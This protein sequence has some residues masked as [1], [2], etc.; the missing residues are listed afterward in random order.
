MEDRDQSAAP[1]AAIRPSPGPGSSRFLDE[2]LGRFARDFK[3][4]RAA[5]MLYDPVSG[6]LSMRAARGFPAFGA[7][8]VVVK[9]GEGASGRVLAERRP[10]YS[11]RVADLRGYKPHP[12]F[13][14][15]D[16]QTFLGIPLLRGRERI[17]AICLWRRT[18]VPFPA[19]EIS[20]ARIAADEC[21][22][23]IEE[24]AR[25]CV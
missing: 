9:L 21:A 16:T 4:D 23:A 11:E 15:D 25:Q 8:T 24:I 10:I 19:E 20:A 2:T 18:G 12:N 17:G 3:A 6:T 13:P 22:A 14:D 1:A 5:L 7:A